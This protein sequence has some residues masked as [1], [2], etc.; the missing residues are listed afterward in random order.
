[1]TKP[2]LQSDC[3]FAEGRL[4]VFFARTLAQPKTK[5][6]LQSGKA[7]KLASSYPA[8]QGTAQNSTSSLILQSLSLNL[9]PSCLFKASENSCAAGEK[10]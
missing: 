8:W 10:L 6:Y 1:M 4:C 7:W 3:V 2:I 9:K 5:M